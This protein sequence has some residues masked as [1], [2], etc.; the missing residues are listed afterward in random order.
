MNEYSDYLVLHSLILL[1]LFATGIFVVLNGPL[2][3]SRRARIFTGGPKAPVWLD[4]GV[5]WFS[6]L[7]GVAVLATWAWVATEALKPALLIGLV[8]V[9]GVF[10]LFDG[11]W[12]VITGAHVFRRGP[13]APAWMVSA[14]VW[15]LRV[16][17]AVA[18]L[19]GLIVSITPT[20]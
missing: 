17:G 8:V 9:V 3:L 6:R 2:W 4:R 12:R 15:F 10:C 20:G 16:V 14:A 18:V 19:S 1:A 13:E 5:P 11:V 7:M